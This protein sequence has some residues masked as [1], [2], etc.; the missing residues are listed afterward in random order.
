MRLEALPSTL[1]Q[2]EQEAVEVLIIRLRRLLSTN[3][4][5][6]RLFGSKA[7]GEATADSDIDLL[8]TVKELDLR[9]KQAIYEIVLDV[10]LE[11]DAKIS[12]KVFTAEELQRSQAFGSPF[13]KNLDREG[14]IL[15]ARS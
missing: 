4:I 9:R 8:L 1:S 5:S 7:R 3:F 2:N 14:I 6:L 11:C 15:A 13:L 12:L 10:D